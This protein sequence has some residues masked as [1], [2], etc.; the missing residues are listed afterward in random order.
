MEDAA[1]DGAPQVTP[2]VVPESMLVVEDPVGGEHALVITPPQIAMNPE[3][4]SGSGPVAGSQKPRAGSSG[5]VYWP[6]T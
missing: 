1:L 3:Q 4:A 5:F 6:G 2:A